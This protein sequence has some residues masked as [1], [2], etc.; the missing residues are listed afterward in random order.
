LEDGE[1]ADPQFL[2][3]DTRGRSDAVHLHNCDGECEVVLD[4]KIVNR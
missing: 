4:L 2:D 1:G 3:H